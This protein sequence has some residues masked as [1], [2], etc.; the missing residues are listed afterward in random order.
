MRSLSEKRLRRSQ[1]VRPKTTIS[2]R[3]PEDIVE[4][5]TEMAPVW[6]CGS[7][8]ALIRL[9]IG[10]GLRRDEAKL[11]EPEV[12][13]LLDKLQREGVPETVILERVSETLQKS[14]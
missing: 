6:G 2:L 5:L 3:L 13:E 10:E 11:E 1:R 14:A 7:F 12:K 4:D 9:Y 8:E